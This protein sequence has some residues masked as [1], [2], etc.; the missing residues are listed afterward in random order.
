MKT[1]NEIKQEVCKD[2]RVRR[3]T[4]QPKI[5]PVDPG[6]DLAEWMLQNPH[7]KW[8]LLPLFILAALMAIVLITVS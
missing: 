2:S 3:V 7:R 8:I 1:L 5:R 6:R 4:E